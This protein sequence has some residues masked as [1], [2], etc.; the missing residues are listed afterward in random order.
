M[1]SVPHPQGVTDAFRSHK[2]LTQQKKK[3][4]R[5]RK[6]LETLGRRHLTNV[7]VVQRNVVYIVNMNPRLA[8]EEVGHTTVFLR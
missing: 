4:D 8:K 6:D 3:R 1:C 2:R 7:R 5:E